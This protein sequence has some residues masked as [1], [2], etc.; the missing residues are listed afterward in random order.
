[1]VSAAVASAAAVAFETETPRF[2][3]AEALALDVSGHFA[4][5]I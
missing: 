2:A 4:V 3:A 5:G 1:M